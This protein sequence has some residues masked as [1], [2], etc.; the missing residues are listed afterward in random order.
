MSRSMRTFVAVEISL[1]AELRSML[2]QFREMGRAVKAVESAATHIT[3]K[4][5]GDTPLDL[6][7]EIAKAIESAMG[8]RE[9]FEL[10]LKGIG[11]FPHWGRPQ[12]VWAGVFPEE[13]LVHI[14]EAL[15]N[16]LE[17]LGFPRERRAFHP[18]LTLAR[19]KAKPPAELKE[20]ADAHETESFGTQIIDTVI[21]YQSELK[22]AGP[23]YTPLSTIILQNRTD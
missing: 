10:E 13:P 11:A 4:F 9:A 2:R 3:L 16:A 8:S 22:P 19:I 18:H 6:L 1:P 21:Y 20:I 15:E 23:V 12:V 7:A 14:A 17:P 5:L